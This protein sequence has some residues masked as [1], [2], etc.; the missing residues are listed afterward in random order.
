MLHL[1]R[2]PTFQANDQHVGRNRDR[3]D[4]E[5]DMM[6]WPNMFDST[7]TPSWAKRPDMSVFRI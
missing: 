3:S 6:I 1:K 2:W 5:L 4:V 7:S